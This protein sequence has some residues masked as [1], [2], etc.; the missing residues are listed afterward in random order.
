[1]NLSTVGFTVFLSSVDPVDLLT[2][3]FT[4]DLTVGSSAIGFW[5]LAVDIVNL[6]DLPRVSRAMVGFNVVLFAIDIADWM[7]ILQKI[8]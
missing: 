4:I 6:K 5:V 2:V 3:G 1:M 7:A 8:C